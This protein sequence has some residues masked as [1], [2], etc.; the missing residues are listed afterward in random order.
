MRVFI[1]SVRR[2]LEE[3]RD[4]L[5]GLISAIG[6]E[7]RRFE[8]YTAQSMPS[9]EACLRGVEGADAYVLLLGEH[10]GDRMAGTGTS[11]TEEEWTV[12]RRRGIPIL[13]FRKRDV[14]P[15]P[16]QAAFIMRIEDYAA[17]VF[18]GTFSTTAQLLTLVAAALREAATAPAALVW[19]PLTHAVAVPW[20]A[21]GR[22]FPSYG[23]IL[24]V[25]L[26]P[27]A[28]SLLPATTLAALPNR[29]SRAGRDHGLFGED[30]ALDL[31]HSETGATATTRADRQAPMAA[32]VWR[33]RVV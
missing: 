1:S 32:F 17:G 26:I 20:Q 33:P 5:P 6:H 22:A 31:V 4:A 16:D 30:R 9:R 29:L 21:F 7:P 15:D 11:P 23:A 27:T 13:A 18:R 12:A 14:A 24:E 25:H 28:G 19:R 8:D 3:E 2:G 10:Y